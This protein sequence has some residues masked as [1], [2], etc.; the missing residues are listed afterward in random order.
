MAVGA[1][2]ARNAEKLTRWIMHVKQTLKEETGK[3]KKKKKKKREKEKKKR[4]KEEEEEEEEEVSGGFSPLLACTDYGYGSMNQPP[5]P[6]T[7]RA[8][9]L[10]L[11]IRSHAA[12]PLC[13]GLGSVH[14]SMLLCTSV[15]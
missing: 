7:P 2:T 4:K 10:P 1:Y 11:E 15:P 14:S 9:C 5:S 8:F 12:V 13:L 6:S 3:K